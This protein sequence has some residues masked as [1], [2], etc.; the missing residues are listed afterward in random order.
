M[1]LAES[2]VPSAIDDV[3]AEWLSQA[4]RADDV[5]QKSLIINAIRVEQIAQD[6]GFSSLLYRVHLTGDAGVPSKVPTAH[7]NRGIRDK[8]VPLRE[9]LRPALSLLVVVPF[10]ARRRRRVGSTKLAVDISANTA[11]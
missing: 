6:T 11:S 9:I 8:A 3:T 10:A 4:L 2:R 5:A 7:A 1:T